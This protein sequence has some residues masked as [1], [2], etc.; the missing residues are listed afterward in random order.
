MDPVSLPCF[1]SFCSLCITDYV[2]ATSKC[3][4]C[5]ST[6]PVSCIMLDVNV[7]KWSAHI[8]KVLQSVDEIASLAHETRFTTSSDNSL[9][10]ISDSSKI[11]DDTQVCVSSHVAS[12]LHVGDLVEVAPRTWPGIN[13]PGGIG[14]VIKRNEGVYYSDESRAGDGAENI[15][16]SYD[17]KYILD[18]RVDTNIPVIFVTGAE[19]ELLSDNHSASSTGRTSGRKRSGRADDSPIS[20]GNKS[21]HHRKRSD[22]CTSVLLHPAPT[23]PRDD[24]PPSLEILKGPILSI[25]MTVVSTGLNPKDRELF[26]A[27][28]NMFSHSLKFSDNID[29][30]TAVVV[31]SGCASDNLIVEKRTMKYMNAII[32]ECCMF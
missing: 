11:T 2:K 20:Y 31:I 15:L 29:A 24:C 27:F 14:W 17:V 12:L 1:H 16:D 5:K 6:A 21:S 18:G 25:N 22:E 19:V 9:I 32:S 30:E 13:K 28:K 8:W 10:K 23:R 7:A 3:P 26:V 4:V